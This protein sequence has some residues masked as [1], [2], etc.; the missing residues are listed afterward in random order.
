MKNFSYLA[1]SMKVIKKIKDTQEKEA[2]SKLNEKYK[3]ASYVLDIDKNGFVVRL[4][5]FHDNL[6]EIPKNIEVLTHLK[7]LDLNSN[8]IHV[9]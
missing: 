4:S 1:I 2:I 8:Q 7:E 9:T 3:L 5:L 6:T